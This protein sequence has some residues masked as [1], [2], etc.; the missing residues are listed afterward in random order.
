MI[1]AKDL[2]VEKG[3]QTRQ[4]ILTAAFQLLTEEGPKGITA[5]K[6]AAKAKISKANLFHHFSR[7]DDIP[8]AVL[9]ELFGQFST[10]MSGKRPKSISEYVYLIG[11]GVIEAPP[12]QRKI[13]AAF[14]H[15]YVRSAHD[16]A[17]RAQ[18]EKTTRQFV[19]TLANGFEE[20]LGRSL[21]AKEREVAPLLVATCLEGMG[22]LLITFKDKEGF[23]SIWK[24][25]SDFVGQLFNERSKS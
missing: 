3:K 16:E 14:V 13:T 15:F 2:R 22:F 7:I 1:D 23:K 21:T 17:F 8:F 9:E 4:A 25:L 19:Q 10:M 5:G 12:Q 18:Q 11:K 20:V 6:L 24:T